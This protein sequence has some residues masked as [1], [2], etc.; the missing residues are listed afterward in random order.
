VNW[1]RDRR[2]YCFLIWRSSWRC[3]SPGGARSAAKRQACPRPGAQPH[4]LASARAPW[5]RHHLLVALCVYSRIERKELIFLRDLYEAITPYCALM[6]TARSRGGEVAAPV[7]QAVPLVGDTPA[8]SRQN[9]PPCTNLPSHHAATWYLPDMQW[10][11]LFAIRTHHTLG[12]FTSHQLHTALL[13]CEARNREWP[14]V[15]CHHSVARGKRRLRR[16]WTC[17]T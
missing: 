6:H 3:T 16:R 17:G 5:P 10:A 1:P 13:S 14:D 4:W 8:A 11:A 15:H 9:A 12:G 2:N 7:A